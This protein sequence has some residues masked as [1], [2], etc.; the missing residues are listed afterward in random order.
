MLRQANERD[1]SRTATM[2]RA[3]AAKLMKKFAVLKGRI[4]KLIAV[5]DA[6]GLRQPATIS[7][8]A[9]AFCATGEGGG[10]DPSCSPADLK[11]KHRK[12]RHELLKG[13]AKEER[14]IVRRRENEDAI[15]Q[16]KRDKEDEPI[17]KQ[18]GKE[19]KPEYERL[20]REG[21]IG[22][23]SREVHPEWAAYTQKQ[24]AREA[25]LTKAKQPARDAEDKAIEDRRKAEDELRAQRHKT[26][27]ELMAARHRAELNG[28]AANSLWD[29]IKHPRGFH[30]HFSASDLP[31]VQQ[32]TH[33]ID[34]SPIGRSVRDKLKSLHAKIEG[35]YGRKTSVA[36][37]TAAQAISWT[38]FAAGPFLGHPGAFVPSSVAALPMLAIAELRYRLQSHTHNVEIELSPQEIQRIARWLVAKLSEGIPATNA[39]CPTGKGGGQKDSCSSHAGKFVGEIVGKQEH[40]HAASTERTIARAIGGKWEEDNKP[41][42]VQKGKD[43]IEVKTFLKGKKQVISMHPDAVVR[44]ADHAASTGSVYHTVAMDERETYDN[45]SHKDNF[46]GH[47]IYYKRGAGRYSLKQMYRVKDLAEL[48]RLIAMKDD[49]LPEQARGDLP[50][51]KRL[52]ELRQLAQHTH[53]YRIEQNR[54]RRE[55]GK[56]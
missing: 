52:K 47:R 44:K 26:E 11:A 3:F 50:S 15:L 41:W 5:D 48:H 33:I 38:S 55:A 24:F 20:L 45:G 6:L 13:R 4:V 18:I 53:Q 12:E 37:L 16:H 32:V 25:E 39:F 36:I 56:I 17:L 51:G 23:G 30:G 14:H 8:L 34:S 40:E 46:S 2:R 1:P 7:M 9:N 10:V 27:D 28:P 35:R 31:G 19:M 42:D 22:T 29:A 43:A 54:K 21:K 49:E